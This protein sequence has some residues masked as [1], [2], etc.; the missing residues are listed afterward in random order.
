M[1]ENSSNTLCGGCQQIMSPTVFRERMGLLI[2]SR[3][4][5]TFYPGV[6]EN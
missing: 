6:G 3:Y 2:T 1:D 5:L 4:L